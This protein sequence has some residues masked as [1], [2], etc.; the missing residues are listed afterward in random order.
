VAAVAAVRIE[1][2]IPK[3]TV[4][5]AQ[6]MHGV[7]RDKKGRM[8][9]LAEILLRVTVDALE[10]RMDLCCSAH[11]FASPAVRLATSISI[12]TTSLAVAQDPAIAQH[13]RKPDANEQQFMFD[14]DLA[15]SDMTRRMLVKPTGDIDRDFV[16]LMIPQHQGAIDMARAELKYGYNNELRR[17][18]QNI[19]TQQNHEISVMRAAIGE[20][21]PTQAGSTPILARPSCGNSAEA[22]IEPKQAGRRRRSRK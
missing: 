12:A 22:S 1:W 15:M 14:N 18:A 2:A 9:R 3:H 16:A 17:R 4:V 21:V 19:V 20:A 8:H 5:V 7:S 11:L 6:S 13:K 10:I